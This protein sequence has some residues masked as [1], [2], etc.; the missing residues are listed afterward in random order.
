MTRGRFWSIAAVAGVSLASGWIGVGINRL[1]GERNSMESPG[2]AVWIAT[3]LTS[4]IAVRLL[5]RESVFTGWNPRLPVSVPWYALGAV[6]FPAVSMATLQFG[7]TRGWVSF[8]EFNL[9][10]HLRN[11]S[12]GLGPAVVKNA[13]EE[14]VWRGYFAHELERSGLSTRATNLIIGFVWGLWHLPYYLYFLPEE[15]IRTVADVSRGQFA[16]IAVAVM[17][18]WS[19]PYTELYRVSESIWPPAL[20]HSVEDVFVN[21]LISDEA[22]QIIP[23]RKALVEPIVGVIPIAMYALLGGAMRRWIPKPGST[24]RQT[25]LS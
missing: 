18:S 24:L 8:A 7:K 11:A 14:S 4:V 23:G 22:V 1:L 2:S 20:M 6:M 3:P 10:H 5:R 12:K 15:E 25:G 21:G 17:A 19:G 16:A 13:F 9:T